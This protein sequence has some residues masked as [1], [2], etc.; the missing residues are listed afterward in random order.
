MSTPA[1]ARPLPQ[2]RAHVLGLAG[3]VILGYLTLFPLAMLALGLAHAFALGSLS[4][5]FALDDDEVPLL[6]VLAVILLFPL[7]SGF[8]LGNILLRR[9]IRL[10][11]SIA[12]AEFVLPMVAAILISTLGHQDPLAIF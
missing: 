9:R 7:V 12:V 3:N 1:D 10:P 11:W 6:L 2:G 4:D 8:L 5:S